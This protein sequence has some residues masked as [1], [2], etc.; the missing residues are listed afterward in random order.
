MLELLG[1]SPE[2]AATEAQTVMRIETALANGSLTQVQRRDPKL[3]YHK[4]TP[5]AAGGAEPILPL[6]EI[7][8]RSWPA[9]V[10]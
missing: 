1:D 8:L 10:A 3:L 2:V 4:M 5:Q 9:R 7:F 6:E